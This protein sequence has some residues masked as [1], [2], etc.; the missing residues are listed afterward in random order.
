MTR[1]AALTLLPLAAC[2]HQRPRLEA[3]KSILLANGYDSTVIRIHGAGTNPPELTASP[4]LIRLAS[5]R[6]RSDVWECAARSGVLPGRAMIQVRSGGRRAGIEITL[7]PQ[8][9]D[10]AADGTPDYLRLDDPSD[11]QSFCGWFTALAEAVWSLAPNERPREISDCSALLRYC[12]RE[13]LRNHD[14]A[15]LAGQHFPFAP[16]MPSV[17]KYCYPY[18]PLGPRL[19]RTR[20]GT[21][22][23]ADSRDGTFSEFADARTLHQFNSYFVSRDLTRAQPADI[24]FFRRETRSGITYHSMIFVGASSFGTTA[25]NNKIYVTYHTGPD[26]TDIGEIKRLTIEELLHFP[27]PEWH[28][29]SANPNFLGL[30]RWNILKV[31]S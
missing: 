11:R 6:R 19:F 23:P 26:G 9:T 3:T 28:P 4:H 14:S 7:S 15:W 29:V 17:V 12:F 30:F 18:T 27:N 25:G 16:A 13:A 21:Y 31:F 20:S 2:S 10:S 1:R 8:I 22:L 24:F 5:L